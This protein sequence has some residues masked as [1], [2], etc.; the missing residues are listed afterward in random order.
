MRYF[1][2]RVV[3]F[4]IVFFLVTFGVM[5]FMRIGLNKPGDPALTMLGGTASQEQIAAATTRYHLDANYLVQYWYFIKG[6]FTLDFGYSLPNN[7]PVTTYIKPRVMT[8]IFLGLYAIIFA[9]LIAV[10]LAI[11]Q[12]YKR[13][14]TFDKVGSFMSFFF[15][16]IPVLVL[17]P[18]A[19]YIFVDWLGWFPRIGEAVYPWESLTEHVKNFFVP[20]LVLTLPLAAVF[21]RLLR[22]DMLQ[23]LQ[24]DFVTLASAKG[25]PPNRI[26]WHHALRN[27]LFSLLTSVGLQIG[28]LIGGAVVVEQYFNMKGMGSLLVVAILSSDLFTVQSVTAVIVIF[29]VTANLIVDLMYAVID[30]RVRAARALT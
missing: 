20:V 24:A 23:T 21:T 30:P 29:V 14:A 2:Q 22:A 15:V 16:S 9:L 26:L 17:A 6:L 4:V 11:Y 5:V 19:A 27:S 25:V 3:Q 8:T 10:P 12:A 18:F 13:D 28:A 1:L 7:L